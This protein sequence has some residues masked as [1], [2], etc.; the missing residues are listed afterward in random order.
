MVW[1]LDNSSR[2]SWRPVLNSWRCAVHFAS[3]KQTLGI[4]ACLKRLQASLDSAT[5]RHFDP[6][7]GLRSRRWLVTRWAVAFSIVNGTHKQRYDLLASLIAKTL[8]AHVQEIAVVLLDVGPLMSPIREFAG[9]A[10]CGFLQSKVSRTCR[11]YD[12]SKH[13]C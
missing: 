13:A 10:I 5:Q 8:R 4:N 6:A 9:K 12:L 11:C 1:V 3:C 2:K 7:E